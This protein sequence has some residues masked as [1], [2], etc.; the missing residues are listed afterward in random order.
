M[1]KLRKLL[2]FSAALCLAGSVLSGSIYAE[3]NSTAKKV[4]VG[5]YDDNPDFQ[6]GSSEAEP[7][8]GYAYEYLQELA[9]YTGWTYE[10]RYGS[11]DEI[12]SLL[13]K[14]EIDLTAG[15]SEEFQK[16]A[17]D[18]KPAEYKLSPYRMGT[19]NTN[20]F[21]IP[22]ADNDDF[23]VAVSSSAGSIYSELTDA[24]ALI[25]QRDPSICDRLA[26]KYFYS[27]KS[28]AGKLSYEEKNWLSSHSTVTIGY[29]DNYMPYSDKNNDK[30]AADGA[31]VKIFNDMNRILGKSI[32]AVKYSTYAELYSAL[33]E[34]EIDAMFPAFRD[35]WRTETEN[36]AA[37]GTLIKDS[38]TVI[39]KDSKADYSVI[40]V[41]S[42]SPVQPLYIN[43]YYP[44]AEIRHYNDMSSCLKAVR[45]GEVKSFIVENNILQYYLSGGKD[46]SDLNSE[47]LK[48][49]IEYCF[50][51]KKSN[52]AL[53][54]I[55]K[56]AAASLDSAE[57]NRAVNQN[58]YVK[59]NFTFTEFLVHNLGRVIIIA[60]CL[61][62]LAVLFILKNRLAIRKKQSEIENA[63]KHLHES[64]QET[65]KYR[66]KTERDHLTGVFSRGHFIELANSKLESHRPN[67]TLQL[68]MMDIDNFK[69]VNDTYGHDNGDVVLSTLGGYL[70]E[71]SRVN[72]FAG[73]F[74]GEEFF[75]FMYGEDTG[76]QEHIINEVCRKLRETDFDFT[77]RHITMSVGVTVI[78]DGDTLD[79]C[80][81]RADKALYYS[82]NHGKN[83][84]N[85]YEEISDQL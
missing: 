76:I 4:I 73:R 63:K 43:D 45:K 74:G 1:I 40:A 3:K 25:N 65:S 60:S 56:A 54:G 81:E 49:D 44:D 42:S 62:A 38:M 20:F 7:K 19:E 70:K 9:G 24:Q 27:N 69:S 77:E 78:N 39:S 13:K 53:C 12:V 46:I 31:M 84:V 35:L 55:L 71:I 15:I 47:S 29:L 33:E 52:T 83:Q 5:Y 30:N 51:T 18:D 41:L 26:K 2:C 32:S 82:K 64:K 14:G 11:F 79:S 34:G 68:V 72:G 75:I 58:L 67:D 57:I 61:A 28:A 50:A 21:N 36:M 80:I 48:Y 8:S 23:Y 16:P 37:T 17:S 85:H 66:Q 22:G 10:Y 59:N 6:S